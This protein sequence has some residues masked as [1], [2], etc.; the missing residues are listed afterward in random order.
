MNTEDEEAKAIEALDGT[1][2]MGRTLKVNKAR[3]KKKKKRRSADC[4]EFNCLT[5]TTNIYNKGAGIKC[6]GDVGTCD[7]TLCCEAPKSNTLRSINRALKEA[8][9]AALN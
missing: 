8:L 1:E 4:L 5:Q 3:K 7:A 9:K 2:F 6:P